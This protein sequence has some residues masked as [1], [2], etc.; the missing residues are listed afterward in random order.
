MARPATTSSSAATPTT[1]LTGGADVNSYKGGTGD[2][3]INA[4]NGK[5]E[6]VDCGAGKMDSASVDKRDKVRGCEKM[7]RTSKDPP[8]DS[9]PGGHSRDRHTRL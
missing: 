9:A 8:V 4:K 3:A 2:D 6:M 5:P 1:K 7:K